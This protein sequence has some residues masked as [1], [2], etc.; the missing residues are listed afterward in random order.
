M[1]KPVVVGPPQTLFIKVHGCGCKESNVLYP[2][3]DH[4]EHRFIYCKAHNPQSPHSASPGERSYTGYSIFTWTNPDTREVKT[5]AV[6][7]HS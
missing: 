7:H 3:S 5:W 2:K 1:S 6:S 4:R